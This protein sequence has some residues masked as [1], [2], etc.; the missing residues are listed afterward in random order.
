MEYFSQTSGALAFA[1]PVFF[2]DNPDDRSYL[3]TATGLSMVFLPAGF[4]AG[5]K[6]VENRDIS[7][8]RGTLLWVTGVMGSLTGLG[9]ASL[10]DEF[11]GIASTRAILASTIA[12]Y[13]GGTLLGFAYKPQTEYT[14]WQSVFIGASSTAGSG[15]MLAFPLLMEVDKHQPFIISALIG[16]WSGFFVGDILSK[17]LFEK[18]SRDKRSSNIQFNLPGLTALPALIASEKF[19]QRRGLS[20]LESAPAMPVANLEWRF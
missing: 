16:G 5:Y 1:L 10:G 8:G 11:H 3:A 7:A 20:C 14:F 12:G 4:Y 13:A 18:T 9:L 17:S 6:L 2:I 15:I 19:G